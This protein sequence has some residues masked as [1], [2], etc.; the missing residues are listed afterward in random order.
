M[1]KL[2]MT[3]PWHAL[4]FVVL[5]TLLSSFLPM[6]GLLGNAALGLI[7]LRLGWQQGLKIALQAAAILTIAL[8]LFYG[9][10]GL[11]SLGMGVLEWALVM[12]LA[13]L[14]AQTASWRYVLYSVFGL[15]MLGIVLFDGFMP[16]AAEFWKAKFQSLQQ[17][18]EI[19]QQFA[20]LKLHELLNQVAPY[21]TGI[22]G[23]GLALALILSLMLARQWQAQLYNAGGFSQEFSELRLGKWPTFMVLGLIG[24][25]LLEMTPLR[26]NLLLMGLM[27]FTL[28]GIALVHGII[29]LRGIH[30]AWLL[31]LYLPLLLI[32]MHMAL[33]LAAFGLV[34]SFAD[35]RRYVAQHKP[36]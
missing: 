20:G 24:L 33:L 23:L 19:Q 12:V 14:L 26:I 36:R 28:Q 4:G 11:L 6:V 35:F 9:Q 27:L 15:I 16:D 7:T 3:G 30:K 25:T 2:I 32:P 29:Q 17:I 18:E 1:A 31:V 10:L 34:D 13:I 5:T 22:L 21:M 8:G